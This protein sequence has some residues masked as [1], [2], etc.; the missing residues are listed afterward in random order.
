VLILSVLAVAL[1][2]FILSTDNVISSSVS[3]AVNMFCLV[4]LIAGDA[5]L[6]RRGSHRSDD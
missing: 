4:A 6:V 3:F 2:G 5:W 1:A